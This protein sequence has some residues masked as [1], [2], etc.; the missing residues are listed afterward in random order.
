MKYRNYLAI[1]NGELND[2]SY[3]YKS[4]VTPSIIMVQNLNRLYIKLST[5]IGF[6]YTFI[7]QIA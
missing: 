1:K 3:L 2:N 4:K 5:L 6:T 7:K